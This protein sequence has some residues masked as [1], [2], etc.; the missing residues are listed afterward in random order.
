MHDA[1]HPPSDGSALP[2]AGAAAAAGSEPYYLPRQGETVENWGGVGEDLTIW[3]AFAQAAI[4]AIRAI[5]PVNPIYLGGN[6]WSAA[7]S[8]HMLNPAWPLQGSNIIYEVH[9]YLDASSSG[10]RFDFDSEVARE[11]RQE[12]AGD[13]CFEIAIVCGSLA[14]A[15]CLPAGERVP[16]GE[17]HD[18]GRVLPC[19]VDEDS[20]GCQGTPVYGTG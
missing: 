16:I 17:G 14:E 9:M 15:R 12:M 18:F 7:M 5:D 8:L 3:P 11:L 13:L 1:P 6:E 20:M 10:Q 4:N 2:T 19:L